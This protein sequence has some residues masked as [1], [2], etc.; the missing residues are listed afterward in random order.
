MAVRPSYNL[1][2][3]ASTAAATVGAALT[4]ELGAQAFP[5]SN[6]K[7][8]TFLLRP[9]SATAGATAQEAFIDGRDSFRYR[10]VQQSTVMVKAMCVYSCGTNNNDF[11]VEITAGVQNRTGSAVLLANSTNVKMPSA[12][13]GTCVLTVS[14]EN[15]VFT[16]TGTAGDTN[17]RWS[18]RMMVEE[19]TDLG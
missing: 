12:A 15:L 13:T 6:G 19:V 4:A 1:T 2:D 11:I 16:C 14:G 7:R 9:I 17:G 10:V 18:I 3:K 8:D 5:D